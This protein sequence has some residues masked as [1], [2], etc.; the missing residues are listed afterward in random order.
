MLYI[1]NTLYNL[2]IL[3]ITCNT[4]VHCIGQLANSRLKSRTKKCSES[5]NNAVSHMTFSV[6]LA[7]QLGPN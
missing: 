5:E 1:I 7:C 4:E 6:W 3:I 2:I